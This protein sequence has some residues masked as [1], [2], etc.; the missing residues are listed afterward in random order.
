L[1]EVLEAALALAADGRMVLPVNAATKAP[2]VRHGVLDASRDERVIREWF[3]RYPDAGLAMRTGAV[4]RRVVADIDGEDGELSLL[5]LESSIGPLP[6]T[7]EALT[8]HG[9]HLHYAYPPQA[10]VIRC[11]TAYRGLLGLDVR[12]DN[13]YVLMPPTRGYVWEISANAV[14]QWPSAL[15]APQTAYAAAS[16]DSDRIVRGTRNSVLASLA[17]TMRRRG[18]SQVAI[19]V[20]LIADNEARC[21]PPLPREEVE[22]IA[23]S[24]SRYEPAERVGRI[25]QTR[26]ATHAE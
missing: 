13:G 9:R 19:R 15:M 14:A 23:I 12:G 25:T 26:S 20:A 17:G 8:P 11:A 10:S 16:A 5:A 2:L 6:T 24:V 3:A 18:M 4:S 1:N 21:T 22:R 7:S